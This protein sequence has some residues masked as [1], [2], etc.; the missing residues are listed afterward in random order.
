MLFLGCGYK[1]KK[2]EIWSG[3]EKKYG[4]WVRERE[5]ERE[6]EKRFGVGK[7]ANLGHG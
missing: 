6:R 5:R 7:R 4:L 3:K 2:S 1:G